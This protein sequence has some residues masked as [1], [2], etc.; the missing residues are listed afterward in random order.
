MFMTLRHARAA[1]FFCLLAWP[2]MAGAD[3]AGGLAG[4]SVTTWTEKEGLPT[5]RVRALAQSGEGYLWLGLE[6]GLVRFDGLRFVR[7]DTEH[8]PAG[9][10]W[11]LLTARDHSLWIGLSSATPIARLQNG[12]LT[13]FGAADGLPNTLAASF[14]ED[15]DGVLW[16]GTLSGLF[17]FTGERWERVDVGDP[18]ST[19]VIG[20]YE[21]GEGRL[22][23]AT[24]A[25]VYRRAAPGA[26]FVQVAEVA[27]A[28]NV[29]FSFSRDRAGT[30][31]V[32][33]FHDGFHRLDRGR[34]PA[35]AASLSGWGVQLLHDRRGDM[36]VATQGQGL[37]RVS[38]P[39][40]GMASVSVATM[41]DGLASEAVQALLEDREGNIWLGTPGGLQR[42]SSHRVTPR[43]DLG[44]ARALE[45]TP[46][47]SMWVGTSSGLKRFSGGESR[48]FTEADGLPGAVVLALH[49]GPRGELWVATELGI[50]I[51]ENGR[52]SP[53]PLPKGTNL[54]R[55]FAIA[56]AGDD[57][58]M[59]DFFSRVHHWRKGALLP[60]DDLPAPFRTD[61]RS[62]H[63]DRNGSVWFGAGNGQ[64]AMRDR[65]GA[66]TVRQLPIGGLARLFEDPAGVL[67]VGGDDGMSRIDGGDVVS[68]TRDQG[69]P[70]SVKSIVE[71]GTG[72]LW[73]GIGTGIIRLAKAE[74]LEAAR[75]GDLKKLRYRFFNA[76]DG[77][78][79]IP[80]AEGTC[81]GVRGADGR[82]WFVT[83]GGLTIVDPQRVGAPPVM[84]P[85]R[86]ESATA[87]SQKFD[88]QSGLFAPSRTSHLHI[89]FTALTLTDPTRIRFRYRL[90]G[91]DHD[92]ID[93]GT[94]REA[95]Y[96]NLPPR[97]Y[98]F[99]VEAHNGDGVWTP[100]ATW[101][102][103]VEPMFYQTRAFAVA[104]AAIA[105]L[106][107]AGVWRLRV[108]SVRR[109]FALV[110][111]E[112]IRMS[113]AIHD[114]LL[115]GLAGLALQMD[116]LSHTL[117]EADA[118]SARGRIVK[119]RR[120]IEEYIREAR[121]SIWDL[122]SP[123]L[124]QS[125]LPNAL[126]Q[127]GQRAI[128][129]RPV[130]LEFTVTGTPHRCAAMVEEQLLLI[131]QEAVS[132]AV[133]H[134]RATRV[135][136]E[137]AYD[138]G[139][140]RL[141]VSDDGCGFDPASLRAANGHYGLVSMRERAEQVKGRVRID[142]AP[143][144]GTLVEAVV[145][146]V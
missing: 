83:S 118:G 85:V 47:G 7:W 13:V 108:R 122:R 9:S 109:Q 107:V 6:T 20:V 46:D 58:W 68:L 139:H 21:D 75:S 18:A 73:V 22:L 115:Q 54:P 60:A 98:R 96:T 12:R 2:A 57:V 81:T 48:L 17:R 64:L 101:N 42:L 100:G 5:G 86:I 44:V 76:A 69:F 136:V 29:H 116:D 94:S 3:A 125:D 79:G 144:R 11:S 38:N 128:G 95:V 87:D 36:W 72:E 15:R 59:R 43:R 16:A 39:D 131:G 88:P 143:G 90:D 34:M 71:D 123:R 120:T 145:P 141:R 93:P 117:N 84:P 70:G 133:Q 66:L 102:F 49:A 134:G 51:Y 19:S 99:V 56:T 89:A 65:A 119:I 62:L 31:W 130:A 126:K 10:V 91:F 37:W 32:S 53:L 114:T 80:I 140:A 110:L 40:S 23:A 112:R 61:L 25:G 63:T 41:R 82:L 35:G 105:A 50:A 14:Y 28:S 137:I 124:A 111:A 52:F 30:V 67:W 8:M 24:P 138:E 132:N 121:Q 55:I 74:F 127:A 26:A 27:V 33:D 142:S 78:A 113:R 135:G 146:T 1:L 129:E 77:V 106:A 92:W 4:Y 104:M 97:Q 103:G 45:A